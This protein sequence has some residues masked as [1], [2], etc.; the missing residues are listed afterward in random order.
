MQA[1][2]YLTDT[3]GFGVPEARACYE[4]VE[5]L[6]HS[7]D[8]PLVLFY[9]LTGQWRYSL[10]T[11]SQSAA[12]QIA[13]RIYTLAQEQEDSALMIGAYRA[14]A[15]TLYYSGDFEAA[16]QNAECGVRIWRSGAVPPETVAIRF[17]LG[18]PVVACLNYQ[19]LSEWHLEGSTSYQATMAEATLL[20]KELNDVHALAMA[21]WHSA[22]L[23]YFER[24]PIEV[25]RHGKDLIELSARYNFAYWL[26]AGVILRGWARSAS[27]DAGGISLIEGGVENYLATGSRI[28]LPFFLALKAEALHLANRTSEALRV[29]A[30]AKLLV[31]KFEERWW[32]AELHRLN[33]VFLATIRADDAQIKASF[34]KA[35][36]T[37][38]EQKST[39]LAKRAEASYAEYCGRNA[40]S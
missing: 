32:Y 27:G 29:I 5:S 4:G 21:Q 37:A 18:H 39:S 10:V 22:F 28:G 11:D 12:L 34:S 20:A 14:L 24:N 38:K 3:L 35:I 6:C 8:R 2:Q 30:E 1:A 15:V 23:A 19:A 16:R 9:A 33:G 13:Q 17:P 7:L 40:D 36:K 25:E 31:E 26:A